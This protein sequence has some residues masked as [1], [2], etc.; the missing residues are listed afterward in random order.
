MNYLIEYLKSFG[1][2]LILCGSFYLVCC[3]FVS[4]PILA[5][6]LVYLSAFAAVGGPISYYLNKEK[7]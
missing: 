2:V 6:Y 7:K 4:D 1:I 5:L 3:H